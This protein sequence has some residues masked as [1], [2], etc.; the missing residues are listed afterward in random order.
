MLVAYVST[1]AFPVLFDTIASEEN[2]MLEF[3]Y[4]LVDVPSNS[5]VLLTLYHNG[6]AQVY[7]EEITEDVVDKVERTISIPKR[8]FDE[9]R[10]ELFTNDFLYSEMVYVPAGRYSCEIKERILEQISVKA[11]FIS[12][13]E[14]TNEQYKQFILADG[15]EIEDKWTIRKDLM[16]DP[17][18][19]WFYQGLKRLT[20]P[21]QWSYRNTP[22]YK[23]AR[24]NKPN[25]PVTGVTWFEIN[26]FC[27]TLN[28]TLP[29]HRQIELL[30]P[31]TIASKVQKDVTAKVENVTT[32]VSEWTLTGTPPAS[33][34][35]GG[36]NE[37]ICFQNNEEIDS[38]YPI[39][40]YKCPLYK[41]S[42]LGFRYVI[43]E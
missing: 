33:S 35:C 40:K 28:V 22:W 32:G 21:M 20:K 12:K 27:N 14:V 38:K 42:G 30:F 17:K 24:L 34:S 31:T 29:N 23:D 26:A 10:M 25:D 43:N 18:I 15:Y 1:L 7:R 37:M 13:F 11:F 36:C 39:E 6:E 19:G 2:E 3:K 5:E 41:N 9:Y 16:K 4:F 8:E